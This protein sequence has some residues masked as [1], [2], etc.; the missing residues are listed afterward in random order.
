MTERSAKRG[1]R[2]ATAIALGISA[3]LLAGPVQAGAS[4]GCVT[5][6]VG[7]TVV[8][9]DGRTF[10][11]GELTLC[12]SIGFNPVVTLH[13]TYVDGKPVGL[14]KS[15]RRTSETAANAEP[16]VVF[17]RTEAGALMLVGYVLPGR[18]STAFVL[19]EVEAPRPVM[20]RRGAGGGWISIA[21]A[22]AR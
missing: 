2:V 9:P 4:G 5:A 22:S 21:A 14:L 3:A 15:E 1:W 16:V 7:S 19:R 12:D 20:A 8:L 13:E 17:Q 11:A 6:E 10:R 18:R